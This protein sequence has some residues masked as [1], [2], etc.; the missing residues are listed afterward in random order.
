MFIQSLFFAL[1]LILSL[2]FFLYGFNHYYLL[3]TSRK[4]RT[5]ALPDL[6]EPRPTISV[7]LPVYNEKNVIR[8]SVA[9]CAAMA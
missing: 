5:P 9:A 3:N 2:L 1:S 4:Y 8:R 7:Q 6:T